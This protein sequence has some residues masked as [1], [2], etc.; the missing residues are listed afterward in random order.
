MSDRPSF[1]QQV[2]LVVIVAFV[3]LAAV[4]TEKEIR[5]E[6]RGGDTLPEMPVFVRMRVD[7]GTFILT[8]EGEPGKMS[9]LQKRLDE[10]QALL[11][12]TDCLQGCE[13]CGNITR[14]GPRTSV[15]T[16]R[17]ERPQGDRKGREIPV[18]RHLYE[19]RLN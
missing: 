4:S 16:I 5:R 17:V 19:V 9:L 2:L 18:S 3:V 14:Y 13:V 11:L 6:K 15:R 10:A 7:S 12:E 8:V 1:L